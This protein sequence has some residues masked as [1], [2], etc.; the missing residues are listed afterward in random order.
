MSE[1]NNNNTNG[2]H[3][4]S[5]GGRGNRS[6]NGSSNGNYNNG[7]NNSNRNS[8]NKSRNGNDSESNSGNYRFTGE[9]EKMEEHV[10][11]ASKF[12]Q[13]E[14][15]KSTKGTAEWVGKTM[16]LGDQIQTAMENLEE[17]KIPMHTVK[18]LEKDDEVKNWNRSQK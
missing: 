1:N 5:G 18:V 10:C 11:G 16:K 9:T 6:N 8:N 3:N 12:P 13:T 2:N 17:C 15:M 14:F 7:N 4:N